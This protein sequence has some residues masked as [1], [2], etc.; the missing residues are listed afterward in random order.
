[1][2]R[3]ATKPKASQESPVPAAHADADRPSAP[4]ADSGAV[5]DAM[6]SAVA[7]ELSRFH[8]G[9]DVLN[10][11]EAETLLHRA[12]AAFDDSPEDTVRPPH[13][14]RIRP[15]SSVQSV[16]T[17]SLSLSIRQEVVL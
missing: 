13:R 5:T 11:L 15:T 6:I 2:G 1:M 12:M 7:N 9:N 8:G 3:T 16:Q 14:S 4:A 17:T 10:W